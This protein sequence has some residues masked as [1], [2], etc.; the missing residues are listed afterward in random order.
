[1][2]CTVAFLLRK[3]ALIVLM[4]L[5]PDG[6]SAVNRAGIEPDTC[7]MSLRTQVA[8]LRR[9]TLHQKHSLFNQ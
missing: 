3:L 1:M 8:T 6:V 5:L 7:A 4:G 9:P 2:H